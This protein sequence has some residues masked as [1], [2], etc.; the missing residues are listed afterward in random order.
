MA[1][2][3]LFGASHTNTCRLIASRCVWTPPPPSAPAELQLRRL[4]TGELLRPLP[5]PGLGSVGG[6]S[7]DRKSPELFFS[8]P[9]KAPAG[10]D[11]AAW[12]GAPAPG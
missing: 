3:A 12:A 1:G 2:I 9:S 7:G 11:G 10:D 4:T 8:Y 5:L 6:L